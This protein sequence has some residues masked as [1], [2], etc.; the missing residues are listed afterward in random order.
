MPVEM[1]ARRYEVRAC[2]RAGSQIVDI[3]ST[4]PDTRTRILLATTVE[5]I[6]PDS[7]SIVV[8]GPIPNGAKLKG[9]FDGATSSAGTVG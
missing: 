8:G 6:E 4:Q 9:K 2:G 1:P 5:V 3:E 7:G